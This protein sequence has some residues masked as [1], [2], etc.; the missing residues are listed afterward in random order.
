MN[1]NGEIRT[2]NPVQA[3]VIIQTSNPNNETQRQEQAGTEYRSGVISYN[4]S[5]TDTKTDRV[6]IHKEMTML[7]GNR[8]SAMISDKGQLSALQ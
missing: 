2:Q 1:F 8:L 3:G 4:D 6:Y 7:M 5:V